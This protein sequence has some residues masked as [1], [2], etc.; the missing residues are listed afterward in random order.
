MLFVFGGLVTKDQ[1]KT[2]DLFWMSTDRMEW[3]LQP[4]T[5]DRPCARDDHCAVWDDT[6]NK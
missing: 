5:G 1:V 4:T 2:N 3:H 6:S